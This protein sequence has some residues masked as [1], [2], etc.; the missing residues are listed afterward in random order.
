MENNFFSVLQLSSHCLSKESNSKFVIQLNSGFKR[1]TWHSLG[2]FSWKH[3]RRGV[4]GR[5]REAVRFPASTPGIRAGNRAVKVLLLLGLLSKHFVRQSFTSS[6]RMPSSQL[7]S[8]GS[9]WV[10][11]LP[12]R[13]GGG[14]RSSNTKY[15]P[16]SRSP[17]PS[18]P[19][20]TSLLPSTHLGFLCC[21]F[22][23]LKA[24]TFFEGTKKK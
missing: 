7:L 13:V 12:C 16:R 11:V 3:L 15:K 2:F 5:Q 20:L 22:L 17:D 9:V 10:W 21:F 6:W 23:W 1:R 18:E 24:V 19:C 4:K 8:E 14:L